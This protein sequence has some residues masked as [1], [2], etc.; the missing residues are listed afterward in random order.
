MLYDYCTGTSERSRY[1]LVKKNFVSLQ[2]NFS[3]AK[4]HARMLLMTAA[5]E[6]LVVLL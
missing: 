4:R 2:M 1:S 5:Q 3:K 6:T